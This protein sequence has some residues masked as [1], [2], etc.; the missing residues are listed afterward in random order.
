MKDQS[1]LY[2]PPRKKALF[3]V[4]D[5]VNCSRLR[6]RRR[7]GVREAAV[8]CRGSAG[9]P[10]CAAGGLSKPTWGAGVGPSSPELLEEQFV[11][12]GLQTGRRVTDTS[13]PWSLLQLLPVVRGLP[14]PGA[15]PLATLCPMP[16]SPHSH[17][18]Q[19]ASGFPWTEEGRVQES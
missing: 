10:A 4:D 3:C 9:L 8:P 14:R 7:R 16:S 12:Q 15:E 11:L 17:L 5:S 19:Q 2:P 18:P 1:L 13:P 6:G